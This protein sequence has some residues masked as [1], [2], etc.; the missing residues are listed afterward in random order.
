[1][2]LLV[3]CLAAAASYAPPVAKPATEY[4][5]V[6]CDQETAGET[7]RSHKR[8]AL[9]ALTLLGLFTAAAALELPNVRAPA[10]PARGA[11]GGHPAKDSHPSHRSSLLNSTHPGLRSASRT[12]HGTGRN[13]S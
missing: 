5:T 6:L 7:A 8:S 2:T 1:M 10:P 9:V 12:H 11:R 4:S 3:V 13:A